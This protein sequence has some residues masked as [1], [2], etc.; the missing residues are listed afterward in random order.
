MSIKIKLTED[1]VLVVRVDA[2]QWTRAFRA[3]LDANTV[4]EVHDADGRTLA[5][6][7]HRILYWEEVPEGTE[8]NR[9]VADR[10]AQPA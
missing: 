3:A 8:Q 2:K 6:N 1:H 7:P 4:I 5:I 10:Q 9:D